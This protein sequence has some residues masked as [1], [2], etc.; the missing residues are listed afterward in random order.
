MPLRLAPGMTNGPPSPGRVEAVVAARPV[1]ERRRERDIEECP[2]A[3][4]EPIAAAAGEAVDRDAGR[5]M[6]A[7]GRARL[8]QLR[9]REFA[10]PAGHAEQPLY[11]RQHPH[12]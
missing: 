3:E 4:Q 6:A 10:A 9:R 12:A 5:D 2:A 11:R 1:L 7:E 8:P